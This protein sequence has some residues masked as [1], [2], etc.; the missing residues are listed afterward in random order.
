MGGH[1]SVI[2]IK[3]LQSHGFLQNLNILGGNK[4]AWFLFEDIEC[5]RAFV[6]YI[7][8]EAVK[9][10]KELENGNPLAFVVIDR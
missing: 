6:C 2:G 10:T 5:F 9:D 3:W 4:R 1:S 7:T 8:L